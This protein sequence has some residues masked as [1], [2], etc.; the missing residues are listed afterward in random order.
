MKVF[1]LFLAVAVFYC[2]TADEIEGTVKID[3]IYANIILYPERK[4]LIWNSKSKRGQDMDMDMEEMEEMDMEEMEDMEEI[5]DMEAM[6]DM[7]AMDII[8][9][10]KACQEHCSNILIH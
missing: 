10:I 8:I 9:D 3:I 6:E 2:A 4:I 7:E 1:L 5:G